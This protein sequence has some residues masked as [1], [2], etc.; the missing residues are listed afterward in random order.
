ME[1]CDLAFD[2]A[3]AAYERAHVVAALRGVAVAA[4]IGALCYVLQPN[5]TWPLVAVLA[6][7]LG[8][9]GWR[10]GAAR[11]GS[12]AGV[13]AGLPPLIAPTIVFALGHG[14]RCPS[15]ELG[16]TLP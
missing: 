13:L 9:L 5:P 8:A 6:A 4:A 14:G 11:R 7:T 1:R 15:C 12:L 10:G 3:R 16:A 2:R